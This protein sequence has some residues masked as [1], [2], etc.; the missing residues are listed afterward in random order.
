LTEAAL[1]GQ[2]I[3]TLQCP[4]VLPSLRGSHGFTTAELNR[5]ETALI[6]DLA[7]PCGE[8]ERIHGDIR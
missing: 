2:A 6:A 1:R 4:D 8:W 3:F 5:I 7:M